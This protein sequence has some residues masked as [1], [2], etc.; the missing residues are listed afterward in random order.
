MQYYGRRL[1]LYAHIMLCRNTRFL[2]TIQKHLFTD[3][4]VSCAFNENFARIKEF[5]NE[6]TR[7]NHLTGVLHVQVMT[8]CLNK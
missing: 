5:I 7:D 8:T 2:L 1:H 6:W 4:T 3:A